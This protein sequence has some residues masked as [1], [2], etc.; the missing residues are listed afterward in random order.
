V[1]RDHLFVFAR[2][3]STRLP[4]KVL[5][6]IEHRPLLGLLLDRME[7]LRDRLE[8]TVATSNRGVDDPIAAFARAEGVNVFRGDTH[9]VATRALRCAV[10]LSAT[11]FVRISADSP[12][13]DPSLVASALDL[14]SAG[15]DI[16]T[17]VYPRTFPR[18]MSVEVVST[19]SLQ[20]SLQLSADPE[21]RE[22]VTRYMYEHPDLFTIAN[23]RSSVAFEAGL[24]L[25]VD[26]AQDMDRARWIASRLGPRTTTASLVEVADLASEWNADRRS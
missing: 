3:D 20:R 26:T 10:G 1:S 19:S 2:L 11:R 22:H 15:V 7:G 12:F 14:H 18:G 6:P 13:I 16:A 21:D 24:S 9:D 25:A 8:T 4:G 23:F 17:N 5:L